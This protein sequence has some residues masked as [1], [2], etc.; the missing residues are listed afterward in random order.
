[1][2]IT[3]MILFIYV[4]IGLSMVLWDFRKVLFN[5]S[6]ENSISDTFLEPPRFVSNLTISTAIVFVLVWPIKLLSK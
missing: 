1:M 3:A 2:L 4:T 6:T 5:R